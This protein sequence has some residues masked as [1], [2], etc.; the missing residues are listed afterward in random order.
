FEPLSDA[1]RE[2]LQAEV[3]AFYG[4]FLGTVAKGRGTRLTAAA[5]RKTEART[6]IGKAAVDA[7]IADRVGSFESVLAELS[8]ASTPNGG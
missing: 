7:G 1:V 5:A 6:F 4:A 3:D 2:D 8:R